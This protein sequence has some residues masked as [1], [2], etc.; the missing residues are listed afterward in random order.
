MDT[1]ETPALRTVLFLA[2]A[3]IAVA[4]AIVGSSSATGTSLLGWPTAA[5]LLVVAVMFSPL[6]ISVPHLMLDT[7][8]DQAHRTLE[9]HGRGT[10]ALW[11]YPTL[12]TGPAGLAVAASI[13]GWIA[14]LLYVWPALFLY[15]A[16]W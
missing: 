12:L 7:W 16:G 13:L 10:A 5:W 3:P 1:T 11:H 4:F 8:H 14:A 2:C 9:R 6:P 15:P